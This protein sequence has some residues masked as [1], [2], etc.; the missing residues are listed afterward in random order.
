MATQEEVDDLKLILGAECVLD[1]TTLS[2]IIDSTST[3]AKAVELSWQRLAADRVTMVNVSEAG[4]SR[5]LGAVFDNTL[6][7][8]Q[9]M[10]DVHA[11][12]VT[13]RPTVVRKI[14]RE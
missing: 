14:V 7:M 3:M 5:S 4:S 9:F 2:E 10:R 13:R 8:A 1:N 12:V 11:P 6:K